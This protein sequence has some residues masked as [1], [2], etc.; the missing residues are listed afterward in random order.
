M[1]NLKLSNINNLQEGKHMAK[2]K[3]LKEQG[4]SKKMVKQLVSLSNKKSSI[5]MSSS[6]RAK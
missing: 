5:T 6:K 4:V 2:Q 1:A 3:S